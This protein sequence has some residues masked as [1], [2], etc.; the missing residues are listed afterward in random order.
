MEKII[1]NIA[2]IT[3]NRPDFLKNC[4]ESVIRSTTE[5]DT[6][7]IVND[8]NKLNNLKLPKNVHLIEH[9][10]NQG[11]CKSKNDALHYLLNLSVGN[12]IFLIEDD[13]VIKDPT[14]FDKYIKASRLT[15]IQHFMFG[16]HGPANRFGH[17]SHAE[18]T[19]K[20]FFKYSD[21][22]K[23]ILNG[24]C[25]G[26]FCYYT[27]QILKEVGL[28]DEKLDKNCWE[29]VEHTYRIQKANAT[30]PYWWWADID[31]S[32]KLI[33]EQACSEENSSIRRSEDWQK[34]ISDSAEY[35]YKKHGYYPA[36]QNCVPH[37]TTDEVKNSLITI[38]KKY[39]TKN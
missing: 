37:A 32:Y 17:K 39:V 23:I 1:K 4:L 34:N 9:E 35:F 25:V 26:A 19:P 13:V 31:E 12:D 24:A 29:H 10:T 11:V 6:I 14:V 3:C 20:A 22:F 7:V 21:D 36:W 16:Y 15:G 18:P 38:Y 30:S 33:D 28:F 8:G 2:I 27:R 5:D